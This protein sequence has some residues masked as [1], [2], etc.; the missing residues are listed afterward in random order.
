MYRDLFG[1]WNVLYISRNVRQTFPCGC[2]NFIQCLWK[3]STFLLTN[4]IFL[5]IMHPWPPASA[6]ALYEAVS[7]FKGGWSHRT[8]EFPPWTKSDAITAQNALS[9]SCSE[10][11]RRFKKKE[12]F[13]LQSLRA[14]TI[15]R[16]LSGVLNAFCR[17]HLKGPVDGS[18]ERWQCYWR[19]FGKP[20]PPSAES[21][22]ERDISQC[23]S[24]E[25]PAN[26]FPDR[27]ALCY[28]QGLLSFNIPQ[29][30]IGKKNSHYV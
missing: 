26:K 12:Y 27:V 18:E 23:F 13:F 20:T 7:S 24:C 29:H 6:I 1:L 15:K 3:V 4:L 21:I 10:C 14:K 30:I 17:A 5:E 2:Q 25:L 8:I 28:Y 11:F 9:S 22:R 16:C 19:C